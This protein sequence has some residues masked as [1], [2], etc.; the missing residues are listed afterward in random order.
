MDEEK[1]LPSLPDKSI[2]LCLTD[3]PFNI[4]YHGMTNKKIKKIQY[5]DNK[6][7]YSN[8]C[9][10]WFNEL[11]RICK[12]IVLFPGNKNIWIYPKPRDTAIHLKKNAQGGGSVC[13]FIRHDIILFY[14][15]F[16]GKLKF[17]ILDYYVDNGFLRTV[18]YIHPCPN[19]I[20]LYNYLVSKLKPKSVIDP[21]MGSGTTAEAC[22][23]LGIPYCG[24][25]K[26]IAY[27]EDID[28][29][30]ERGIRSK[31]A[32]Q[33]TLNKFIGEKS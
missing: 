25:E 3:P 21:F 13:K 16:N 24:Y 28:K 14:G 10:K 20:K 5:E 23:R 32:G 8:W 22:I 17:S 11:L 26:E 9:L 19:N 27:K 7:D 31:Q 33:K 29:R 1:G 6:K 2:D 15:E 18:D 30:I 4:K 12:G